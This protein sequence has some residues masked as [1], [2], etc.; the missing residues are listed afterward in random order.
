MSL[1]PFWWGALGAAAF[2]LL[3]LLA[4]VVWFGLSAWV[5]AD[6]SPDTHAGLAADDGGAS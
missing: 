1:H 5:D 2:W 4:L 3:T 6:P